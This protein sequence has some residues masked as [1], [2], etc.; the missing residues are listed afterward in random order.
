MLTPANISWRNKQPYAAQF[1]DI[2][3]AEDGPAEVDRVFLTPCNLADQL[4]ARLSVA[5]AGFGTGLNFAVL[6]ERVIQ[7][8][9]TRL[10][11]TSFEAQPLSHKDW[12]KVAETY[13]HHTVY[14][15][16]ASNPPPL[17]PGWHQRVFADGRIVLNLFHG[18]IL[19]GLDD[20]LQHTQ[21][22]INAW[23]LDGFA[24]DRNP[25]MWSPALFKKIAA[26]SV[27]GA[28]LATFTVAGRVRRGLAEVGFQIERIDQRPYKRESLAATFTAPA[29]LVPM[30]VE[31]GAAISVLGAGLAGAHVARQLAERG[32]SVKVYDPLGPGGQNKHLPAILMHGRLLGD[33]SAQADLRVAALHAAMHHYQRLLPEDSQH[34]CGALQLP[35]PNMDEAKLARVA[36]AYD[37]D[38]LQNI[39]WVS[40]LDPTAASVQAGVPIASS[41]LY[42]P[43]AYVLSPSLVC[44]HLLD[45]PNIEIE[46]TAAGLDGTDQ[47]LCCGSATRTLPGLDWLELHD[48]GGQLTT[49]SLPEPGP[50]LAIVGNGYWLPRTQAAVIGSSYE[51]TP[52][53]TERALAHN[54]EINQAL[55]PDGYQAS[56]QHRGSRCITSDRT[57]IVGPVDTRSDPATELARKWLVTGLGSMGAVM[58]PYAASLIAG[59]VVDGFAPMTQRI[60]KALAPERFI[61]RQRRRGINRQSRAR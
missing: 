25:Q 60:A 19:A 4:P 61:E 36:A 24:P 3:Y 23:F 20:W 39:E 35:G 5:E 49:L 55:L 11:F 21:Y 40:L 34:A 38:N 8:P 17:L 59:W 54:L 44:T 41:A 9:S 42:F 10:T 6:A 31:T 53:S 18:D 46:H 48:V 26:S 28:R 52:W 50:N 33:S 27:S 12:R 43:D 56:A 15:S 29:A 45:H 7:Q 51:H 57:P 2:Y 47:V 16:L 14:R 22:G 37:A 30:P 13:P 1:D 58:A 32:L